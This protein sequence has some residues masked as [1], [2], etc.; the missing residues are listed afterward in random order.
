MESGR[1][2]RWFPLSRAAASAG[3]RECF[4]RVLGIQVLTA[5]K[6][7]RADGTVKRMFNDLQ[8]SNRIFSSQMSRSE[9]V[10]THITCI[11]R[12]KDRT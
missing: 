11:K 1:Y 7:D 8:R 4:T 9:T 10:L 3:V 5:V 6:S 2:S 12:S